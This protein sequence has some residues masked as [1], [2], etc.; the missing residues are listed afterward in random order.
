[1]KKKQG[2]IDDEKMSEKSNF[3]SNNHSKLIYTS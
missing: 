1:M 2:E 3:W